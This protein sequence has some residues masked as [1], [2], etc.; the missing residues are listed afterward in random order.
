MAFITWLLDALSSLPPPVIIIV[1]AMMPFIE[2]RGS[3]PVAIGIYHMPVYEAFLWSF[4][5][6]MLP[7]PFILLFFRY[8][9][10]WLRHWQWWDRT[11]ERLF[12]RT[13][14]RANTTIEKYEELGIIIFVAIPLPFTGAWTGALIAYLFGLDTKKALSVI[15][16]GVIIAGI[17]VSGIMVIANS[18][19]L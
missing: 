16:F 13:R 12:A 5:G 3:I 15:A 14:K 6:N 11:F 17:I 8:I 7:I 9:E 19:F 18:M 1:I 10:K 2:L 4:I